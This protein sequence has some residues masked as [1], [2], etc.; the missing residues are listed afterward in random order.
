M[1]HVMDVGELAV[2]AAGYPTPLVPPSDLDPL[3]R[4]RIPT[5]PSLVED[6]SIRT[7]D[8]QGHP[9]VTCQAPSNLS[10]HR[11][12]TLEFGHPALDPHQQ[13]EG[14]VKDEPGT[15][16]TTPTPTATATATTAIAS[17]RMPHHRQDARS[18]TTASAAP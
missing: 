17:R 18:L 5:S 11:T 4:R 8:R 12:H 14:R 15:H 3:R 13:T 16:R 9:G 7:L 1:S 6:G 10:R 2:G